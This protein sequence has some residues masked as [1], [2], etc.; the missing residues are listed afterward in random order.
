MTNRS[1]DGRK[2]K[3]NFD[4]PLVHSDSSRLDVSCINEAIRVIDTDCN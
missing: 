1:S 2:N 3:G 4:H